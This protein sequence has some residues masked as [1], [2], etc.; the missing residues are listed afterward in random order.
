[1][2]SYIE[3]SSYGEVSSL[4]SLKTSVQNAKSMKVNSGLNETVRLSNE[5]RGMTLQHVKKM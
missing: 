2:R 3:V 1:M 5:D 4:L